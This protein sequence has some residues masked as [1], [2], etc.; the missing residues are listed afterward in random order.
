MWRS[1]IAWMV[2]AG[3][4]GGAPPATPGAAVA[5][6]PGAA[7]A[8]APAPGWTSAPLPPRPVAVGPRFE[9]VDPTA[10]GLAFEH[11]WAPDERRAVDFG[12]AFSGVGLARL[13]RNLGGFRFTD[14]TE[15]AGL[16][17]GRALAYLEGMI[18]V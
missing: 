5:P 14:V 9:S 16:A 2:C 6:V 17:G 18:D 15:K 4:T 1:S 11:H 7:V 10:A 12:G 3:C 13:F 8:P